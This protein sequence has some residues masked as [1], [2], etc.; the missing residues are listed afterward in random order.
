MAENDKAMT[1][2][3]I[4]N[5]LPLVIAHAPGSNSTMLVVKWR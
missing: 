1:A 4:L 5:M 2:S 3:L